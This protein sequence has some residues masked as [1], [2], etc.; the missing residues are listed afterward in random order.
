[1]DRI[2][3]CSVDL[4]DLLDLDVEINSR[5][6]ACRMIAHGQTELAKM[7][8]AIEDEISNED[9]NV[10]IDG[11]DPLTGY[12]KAKARALINSYDDIDLF[13]EILAEMNDDLY[14]E[15]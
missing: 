1:M 13:L 4:D 6:V 3:E 11:T 15:P 7:M 8:Y 14:T 2:A 10:W 5:I 12:S 9:P